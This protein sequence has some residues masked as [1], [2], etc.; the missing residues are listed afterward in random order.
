MR[1]GEFDATADVALELDAALGPEASR[2]FVVRWRNLWFV[3]Q[4]RWN[5][6]IVGATAFSYE[7]AMRVATAFACVCPGVI[8]EP[9]PSEY[10]LCGSSFD[11]RVDI[12]APR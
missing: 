8:A 7:N 6:T 1:S 3:E 2:M 11:L 4:D 9:L 10:P 5:T 12:V